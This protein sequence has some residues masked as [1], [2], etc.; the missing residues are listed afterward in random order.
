MRAVTRPAPRCSGRWITPR[1]P[2]TSAAIMLPKQLLYD[3]DGI[4]GVQVIND[5]GIGV[6]HAPAVILATGGL[7]HLYR[8]TTNPEGSTGDGIALALCAGVPV[9]DIEFIQFH[10][11]MLYDGTS[12]HGAQT[13][14]HRGAAGGGRQTG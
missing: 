4:T 7:G 2:S 12:C 1:R 11:T 5:D 13:A 10:P 14:D 9:S 6:V 3:D 8:A